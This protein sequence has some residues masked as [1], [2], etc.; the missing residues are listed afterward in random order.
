MTDKALVVGTGFGCRIQVPALRGAGFEVVG[1]VGSDAARTAERAEANGVPRHFTDLA[2]A[3]AETG[4]DGGRNAAPPP[5][6]AAASINGVGAGFPCVLREAVSAHAPEA[7]E[8]AARAQKGGKVQPIRNEF[9][10]VPQ[11]ATV[12]RAI[13]E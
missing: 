7:A 5:T 9:R 1:L 4:A 10:F 8:M 11:R 3:I 12:G 6:D 2:E 13:A